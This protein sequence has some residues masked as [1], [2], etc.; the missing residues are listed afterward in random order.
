MLLGQLRPFPDFDMRHQMSAALA[1]RMKEERF[2]IREAMGVFGE[3]CSDIGHV[4]HDHGVG[5]ILRLLGYPFLQ[6]RRPIRPKSACDQVEA[7]NR[8]RIEL[9]AGR[10]SERLSIHAHW[11]DWTASL[12]APSHRRQCSA[13][14]RQCSCVLACFS[15]SSAQTRHAVAHVR[16][17]ATIICSL[18]PARRM[19]TLPAAMQRSAQ[20]RLSRMHWRS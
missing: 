13:Q 11:M 16:M 12:Q 2:A 15:H 10:R 14:M 6:P 18:L 7:S 5:S 17:A 9:R 19:P 3:R 20:S 8:L 4:G 1:V